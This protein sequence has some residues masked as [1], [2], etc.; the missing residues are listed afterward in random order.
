MTSFSP[1]R[2]TL[3]KKEIDYGMIIATTDNCIGTE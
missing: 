3:Y 2:E 1:F